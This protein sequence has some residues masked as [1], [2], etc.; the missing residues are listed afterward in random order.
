[1]SDSDSDSDSSDVM[2]FNTPVKFIAK[3]RSRPQDDYD[4][5]DSDDSDDSSIGE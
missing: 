5:S 2:A 3:K 4:D 1:M